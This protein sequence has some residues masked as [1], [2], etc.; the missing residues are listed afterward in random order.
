MVSPRRRR[1]SQVLIPQSLQPPLPLPSLHSHRTLDSSQQR[2]FCLEDWLDPGHYFRP[3]VP[4]SARVERTPSAIPAIPEAERH[5]VRRK[6]S[7]EESIAKTVRRK[8]AWYQP[9]TK[10][11]ERG[12]TEV[13]EEAVEAF[14]VVKQRSPFERAD[15]LRDRW[16][17]VE[18]RRALVRMWCAFQQL[19]KLTYQNVYFQAFIILC[20]LLN[21]VLLAL[22]DPSLPI[23]PEPYNTMELVLLCVYTAEMLIKV[24]P[25][26]FVVSRSAYLRDNWNKM[27]CLVV[28]AGWIELLS[29][30]NSINVSALRALRLL[31]PL[32]SITRIYGMK[33]ILLSLIRSVQDLLS[34]LA[35]L[36]FFYLIT[37]IAALQLFM[38]VLKYRCMNVESGY[39]EDVTCG[40]RLCG[41]GQVCVKGLDNTNYGKT[42][43]DNVLMA[44][45]TIFQSVTLEGWTDVMVALSRTFSIFS[46]IFYIPMVFLGAFFFNN[47]LLIAM[48]SAVSPTQFTATLLAENEKRKKKKTKL[49]HTDS[50]ESEFPDSPEPKEGSK[51]SESNLKSQSEAPLFSNSSDMWDS[52]KDLAGSKTTFKH[53]KSTRLKSGAKLLDSR[54][55]PGKSPITG[56]SAPENIWRNDTDPFRLVQGS[57]TREDGVISTTAVSTDHP[58]S[59]QMTSQVDQTLIIRQEVETPTLELQLSRAPFILRQL[60]QKK[61]VKKKHLAFGVSER[62]LLPL[63]SRGDVLDLQGPA[64]PEVK[65]Q[66]ESFCYTR[67]DICVES[68]GFPRFQALSLRYTSKEAYLQLL[69]TATQLVQTRFVFPT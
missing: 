17:L 41:S 24:I 19:C 64:V 62:W 46:V 67:G 56:P 37:S 30:G 22:E 44:M 27:D 60:V 54:E 12:R 10:F 8:A 63:S 66:Q 25:M 3:V 47:M 33:I 15:L 29:N 21:T 7:L 20:I 42:N 40:N 23:Q 4:T 39:M 31:R 48:K 57:Y 53:K 34:S 13:D 59:L 38:G 1:C 26:G 28:L 35:L 36:L 9:H 65:A 68:P 18:V 49:N 61:L 58:L 69:P 2:P 43:F 45:L 14:L 16:P 51:L 52:S 11:S 55:D 50:E 6:T 5:T 32:R